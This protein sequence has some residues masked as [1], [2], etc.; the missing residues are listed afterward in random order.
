M[1]GYFAALR[2]KVSTLE[3]RHIWEAYMIQSLDMV[4]QPSK[5]DRKCEIKI[6]F[7][8]IVPWLCQIMKETMAV[9]RRD[10]D[11]RLG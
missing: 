6:Y 1:G 2:M 5:R 7:H 9:L 3:R 4:F 8:M 10:L 11:L